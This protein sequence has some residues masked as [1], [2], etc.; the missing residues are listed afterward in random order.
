MED[1][2]SYSGVPA[3]FQ[4]PGF[5]VKP[6]QDAIPVDNFQ[7]RSVGESLFCSFH[8]PGAH[9]VVRV[10]EDHEFC[11]DGAKPSVSCGACSG[12]VL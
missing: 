5:A 11:V 7:F 12:F 6:V 9:G 10:E 8:K 4:F 1:L 3:V 2:E